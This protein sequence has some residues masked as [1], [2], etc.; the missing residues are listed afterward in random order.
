MV[1]VKTLKPRKFIKLV[2]IPLKLGYL[3]AKARFAI[4]QNNENAAFTTGLGKLLMFWVF[5]LKFETQAK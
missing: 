3:A 5:F 1:L 4:T 2:Q